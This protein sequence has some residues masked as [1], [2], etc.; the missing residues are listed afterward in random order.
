[1]KKLEYKVPTL[2]PGPLKKEIIQCIRDI[3]LDEQ[4]IRYDEYTDGIITGCKL[5]EEGMKIG[6]MNGIVKFGGRLYKLTEKIAVH[7]EPTDAWTVLKMQ[8]CPQTWH[9]E[10]TIFTADLVL[11]TNR[12]LSQNELE[13]GRF[14][15][16][17]GSYLRTEYKDFWDMGTE[18]DTVNLLHVKQSARFC[19][20]L[21]P[22]ITRHFAREAYRHC[23][24][25]PLD[26]AFCAAC[27]ATGEAVSRELIQQYVCARKGK[28]YREMDNVELHRCLAELLD[29]ITGRA[30]GSKGQGKDRGIMVI[31]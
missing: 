16:K 7:Y 23:Q 12:E 31:N 25:N 17:K 19:S 15:L 3:G 10:Y 24:E 4:S 26:A 2:A 28:S 21:S 20:T 9:P 18:Y 6:L 14:K 1:M 13:I 5:F 27:L 29:Q 22:E 30:R 8:F 11:D